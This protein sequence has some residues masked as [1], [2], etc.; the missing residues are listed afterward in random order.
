MP[1]EETQRVPPCTSSELTAPGSPR[2][3][4]FQL[5]PRFVERKTPSSV[6]AKERSLLIVSA[7]TCGALPGPLVGTHCA[8]TP[9][10]PQSAT[11]IM[12]ECRSK[13]DVLICEPFAFKSRCVPNSIQTTVVQSG[14]YS[15][16]VRSDTEDAYILKRLLTFGSCLSDS[17]RPK[18]VEHA[19][20]DQILR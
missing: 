12:S 14:Y 19:L 4:A 8:R 6:P 15:R 1:D 10:V 18:P 17:N 20:L 5:P 11:A 2:P 7:F 13:Q 3:A 9:E 16:V